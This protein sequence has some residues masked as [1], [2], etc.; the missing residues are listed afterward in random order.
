MSSQLKIHL[1]GHWLRAN[2]AGHPGF[3]RVTAER[4][5]SYTSSSGV[6]IQGVPQR[7]GDSPRDYLPV[8]FKYDKL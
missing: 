8:Q 1:A 5:I 6:S 2:N 3:K 7:P 4:P